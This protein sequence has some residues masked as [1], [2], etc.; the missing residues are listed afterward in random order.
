LPQELGT[1]H[2]RESVELIVSGYETT[3]E[4]TF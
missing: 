1:T 4:A 2:C 3:P